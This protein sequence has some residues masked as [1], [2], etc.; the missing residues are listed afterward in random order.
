MLEWVAS[1]IR[2]FG[3]DPDRVTAFGSGSGASSIGIL[4]LSAATE[5]KRKG[6][7]TRGTTITDC[8]YKYVLHALVCF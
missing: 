4:M 1:N 3:G 6:N 7:I 5:G 8:M 2:D